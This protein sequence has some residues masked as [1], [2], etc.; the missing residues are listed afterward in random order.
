[1]KLINHLQTNSK[2]S[3]Y[4]NAIST[5]QMDK[6]TAKV[7]KNCSNPLFHDTLFYVGQ[8]EKPI[9]ATGVTL[10]M[11]SEYFTKLLFNK[12]FNKK[13]KD[14]TGDSHSH[15]EKA[16]YE[17]D[18]TENAFK[19]IV[20]YSHRI[21]ERPHF[22]TDT[23][24]QVLYASEKYMMDHLTSDGAKYLLS[25]VNSTNI[26][27]FLSKAIKLQLNDIVQQLKKQLLK[28]IMNSDSTEYYIQLMES[29]EFMKLPPDVISKYFV[30]NDY[31]AVKEEIIFE[32]CIEYC[33]MHCCNNE[34]KD[35]SN[36][37]P[38]EKKTDDKKIE[39]EDLKSVQRQQP[40]FLH[41]DLRK[42]INADHDDK[43]DKNGLILDWRSMM[44]QF[45]LF[46]IRFLL[47][48]AKYFTETVKNLKLFTNDETID[49]LCHM[50]NKNYVSSLCGSRK[51][52][53]M[54]SKKKR[55]WKDSYNYLDYHPYELRMSS[56]STCDKDDVRNTYEALA[57]NDN[58]DVA[59]TMYGLN[60]FIEAQ[61]AE[62][63]QIK[64]I[65]VAAVPGHL[66][67]W[68]RL[69]GA[70]LQYLDANSSK[71]INIQQIKDVKHYKIHKIK[72]KCI[73]TTSIRVANVGQRA[74]LGLG[75]FRIRAVPVSK[76]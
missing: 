2:S 48:D 41:A 47:M 6:R 28:L 45:F 15:V 10:A 64:Q 1:M 66:G 55:H 59:I 3:S 69:N 27:L 21:H 72:V 7:I 76:F 4:C 49:V 9:Y 24:F 38:T 42:G 32:K 18:V 12:N 75:R 53:L 70:W 52:K 50:V 35:S 16:F 22:N 25:N 13:P 56:Q 17:P 51:S 19:T 11:Q 40:P 26:A 39:L 30:Q 63:M 71:W 44:R 54:F 74:C 29:N 36:P 60:E 5:Y 73:E 23:I 46:D 8:E 20:E 68:P 67:G 34:A 33:Q 31:F 58:A 43:N 61:F 57:S 37:W 14:V 65:D 62:P